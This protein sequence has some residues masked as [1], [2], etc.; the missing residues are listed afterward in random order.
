MSTD[1]N[2]NLESA[3]E[4]DPR[5]DSTFIS[6]A[7]EPSE[8]LSILGWISWAFILFVTF[9][10]VALTAASQYA[11][12]Q[13]ET[14][15][16]STADLM[17]IELQAKM[18]VGQSNLPFGNSKMKLEVPAEMNAG[19]YEQHVAY[20]VLVSEIEGPDKAMPALETLDELVAEHD[21]QPTEQQQQLRN[22]VGRIV[23][24]S[25]FEDW[26]DSVVSAE[27]NDLLTERL[28]WLGELAMVP[29]A[30]N[31]AERREAVVGEA[32]RS[33]IFVTLAV[34]AGMLAMLAGFVILVFFFVFLGQ[35]KLSGKFTN[36]SGTHNIYVETFAIWMFVF[37]GSQFL[38]PILNIDITGMELLIS[39][40]LM[41]GSLISLAWPIVRG[42][43]LR[44]VCDDIGLKSKTPFQDLASAPAGYLATMPL[45]L[46]AVIFVAILAMIAAALMSGGEA[47]E[48]SSGS[49]MGSHPIQEH[50]AKGDIPTFLLI[51]LTACVAAP[52]VEEIMFRGVLY[53]HLRDWSQKRR[54]FVSVLFSAFLNGLI[55][56]AIHPQGIIAIPLLGTLAVAFSL[57]REW[58]DSLY[59]SMIMHAI[60]NGL[61]TCLMFL[62]L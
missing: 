4:D 21:F 6:T 18:L 7:N 16:A 11:D 41:F 29:K 49:G 8:R 48:F 33:A 61:V 43:T 53:R 60:N 5:D 3:P 28:G 35:G 36:R 20:V 14:A 19:T 27:N 59:P 44:Q 24:A 26:D 45:V 12:S 62:I 10:I 34:G 15:T 52:I 37:W 55:F 38:L 32:V 13:D 42:L 54:R 46:I 1:P 9:G 17:Q 22:V 57:M 2:E 25:H 23:E 47:P 50:V 30:A 51:V 58:R 39:P 40:L 56:A 31:L